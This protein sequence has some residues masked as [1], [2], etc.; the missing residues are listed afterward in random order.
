MNLPHICTVM[1]RT[2]GTPGSLGSPTYTWSAV[3]TPRCRFYHKNPNP[4][5]VLAAGETVRKIPMVILPIAVTP[6]EQ[7]IVTTA[8]GYAGTY[9]VKAPKPCG[10]SSARP[11]HYEAELQGVTP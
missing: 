8:E 1:Q 5:Q 6:H 3:A 9:D 11:H 7:R 10:G 2:A 4:A